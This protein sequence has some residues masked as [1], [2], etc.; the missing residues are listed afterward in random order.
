MSEESQSSTRGQRVAVFD[1][2]G[3]SAWIFFCALTF[4]ST[5]SLPL[6]LRDLASGTPSGVPDLPAVVSSRVSVDSRFAGHACKESRTI[7]GGESGGRYRCGQCV[8]GGLGVTCGQ[9][10]RE[11]GETV[12]SR[13]ASTGRAVA[14]LP[15]RALPLHPR[16]APW[17]SP[18]AVLGCA[19]GRNVEDMV[20]LLEEREALSWPVT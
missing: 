5:R 9:I 16:W 18:P 2:D 4:V 8:P 3:R 20:A 13:P 10:G 1:Y 17:P 19:V 11:V 15:R 6:T 7:V 12:M 14:V